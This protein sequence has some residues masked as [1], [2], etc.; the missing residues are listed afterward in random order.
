MGS[1]VAVVSAAPWPSRCVEAPVCPEGSRATEEEVQRWLL[2]EV[3][4]GS[5]SG[6]GAGSVSL[7]APRVGRGLA[8][9]AAGKAACEWDTVETD[10]WGQVCAALGHLLRAQAWS[11]MGPPMWLLGWAISLGPPRA[12]CCPCHWEN[13]WSHNLARDPWPLA[14][15]VGRPCVWEPNA[16]KHDSSGWLASVCTR[17]RCPCDQGDR[18][19]LQPELRGVGCPCRLTAAELRAAREK[20]RSSPLW[21]RQEAPLAEGQSVAHRATARLP[22]H[23]C[24][25]LGA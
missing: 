19:C 9:W 18:D 8:A 12:G 14:A 22:P 13:G 5:C 20:G 6:C 4:T 11:V 25:G 15:S 2:S 21:R 7:G 1:R 17:R 24:Q 3:L 10:L 16:C 23:P